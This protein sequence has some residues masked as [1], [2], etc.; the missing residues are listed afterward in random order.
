[1]QVEKVVVGDY[2]TNCYVISQENKCLIVDPGFD[3]NKII[4]LINNREVLAI[5]ITH[6]HD[7]HIGALDEIL[8][9]YDVPVYE[10]KNLEEKEYT[11]D[12]FFFKV[13]FTKGH[14]FDSVTYYFEK[15]KIMF[16]GDFIFENSIGRTDLATGDYNEMIESI[17]KIKQYDDDIVIYPGHGNSTKLGLE[18]LNNYWFDSVNQ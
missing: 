12:N 18:K 4:S 9:L 15:E 17:E 1:M 16:V 3:S 11:I 8:K 6:R 14:T 13:I 2:Q 5:L 7:D 10:F